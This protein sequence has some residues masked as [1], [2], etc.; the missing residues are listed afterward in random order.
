MR[1]LI[2]RAFPQ[3]RHRRRGVR[4]RAG[5]AAD[6]EYVW[7]ARSHR[8]HPRLHL[9]PADL[10]HPDRPHAQRPALLRPDAPALH[11]VS[12]SSATAAS[13]T[14]RGPI[15]GGRASASGGCATRRCASL[16]EATLFPPSTS[17]RKLRRERPARRFR[18]GGGG[19]CRHVRFG[20]RLLR[21][22]HGRGR[23]RRS[24]DR[25]GA[26]A[27]RHRG[28]DPDHRGRGR[29]RAPPGKGATPPRGVHRRRRETSEV[30]EAG[31]AL[32]RL[33]LARPPR[34]PHSRRTS[35]AGAT[36]KCSREPV[37]PGKVELG[38]CSATT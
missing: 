16:A 36:Q 1:H 13:S 5:G 7:G 11:R 8:R 23:P 34:P 3:P 10:G 38:R 26:R 27:L 37:E 24:R 21:L 28:A 17:P 2:K 19:G 31:L 4:R 30:H 15:P 35:R 33:S 22:L 29:H 6:A 12:A 20:L 25:G 9:R 14:Y 32:S 18:A